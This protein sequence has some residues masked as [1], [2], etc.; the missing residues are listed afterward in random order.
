[1]TLTSPPFVVRAPVTVFAKVSNMTGIQLP[2]VSVVF[3]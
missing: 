1:M 2:E 3:V